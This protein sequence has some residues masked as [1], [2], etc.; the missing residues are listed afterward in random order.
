MPVLFRQRLRSHSEVQSR[1]GTLSDS[2]GDLYHPRGLGAERLETFP[3][4]DSERRDPS[5]LPLAR[6]RFMINIGIIGLGPVWESYR[7]VLSQLRRP[8]Q[9]T[10]VYDCVPARAEQVAKEFDAAA[11]SGL[12]AV[13]S[14]ND[15][16]AILLMETGWPGP[17]MLNLLSRCRKPVFI[18]SWV[19]TD[20][21]TYQKWYDVT[22]QEGI[23]L[24]PAMWRR[25]LPATVRL[26]ELIATEIGA[27]E[28]ISL[29]LD[30]F[31]PMSNG[32]LTETILGWL[33]LVWYLIRREPLTS[34]VRME[35]GP[36]ALSQ[37]LVVRFPARHP[38]PVEG[39]SA[40]GS[41]ECVAR[42][43]LK[44]AN[45]T[46][47]GLELLQQ[48]V[49]VP[50]KTAAT[51]PECWHFEAATVPRIELVCECG[52]AT[53]ESRSSISWQSR[54]STATSESLVA[55]RAE[56]VVMLDHFCRRAVGGLIP[57][58]DYNDIARALKVLLSRR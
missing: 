52:T 55:E 9:V 31:Q 42:I 56:R 44:H 34:D 26:K 41:R 49:S 50:S 27:P 15:V 53:V 39:A 45:A 40:K 51:G 29:A 4:G 21:A 54:E 16:Q 18:G 6:F 46:P 2:D 5:I 25:F 23:T 11:V 8:P 33:D 24:M 22:E 37:T 48:R 19:P 30:L 12:Q 47:E 35:V 57:V 10:V 13:A 43:T 3:V 36:D 58:A 7:A 14:R 17:Q 38:H 32:Q 28:Q 1:N 20:V